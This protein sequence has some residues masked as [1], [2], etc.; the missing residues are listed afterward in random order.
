MNHATQPSMDLSDRPRFIR[1]YRTCTCEAAGCNSS[2]CCR[3]EAGDVAPGA[4]VRFQLANLL[5]T[6]RTA[7]RAGWL[8]ARRHW[9]L[10]Q[11][12][13]EPG[14]PRSEAAC[15]F[16]QQSWDEL[17]IG[18]FDAADDPGATETTSV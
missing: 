10:R 7:P 9:W 13:G 11:L 17:F 16:G 6:R 15:A 14:E 2:C 1:S 8:L 4:S 18:F 3:T 5:S 12:S